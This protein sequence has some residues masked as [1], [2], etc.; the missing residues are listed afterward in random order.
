M[1][2]IGND[3]DDVLG[4]EFDKDYYQQLRRFLD[5]E[6]KNKTIHDAIQRQSQT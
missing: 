1:K 6:Y 2:I 5:A 4:E 3:W